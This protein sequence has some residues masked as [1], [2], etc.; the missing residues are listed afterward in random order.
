[1]PATA[2]PCREPPLLGYGVLMNAAS[3]VS[4]PVGT[5][6]FYSLRNENFSDSVTPG[7]KRKK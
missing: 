3:F 1:M 4:S 2:A 5:I 7:R 6:E